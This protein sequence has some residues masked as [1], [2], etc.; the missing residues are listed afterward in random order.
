MSRIPDIAGLMAMVAGEPQSDRLVPHTG[1]S[2]RLT[3]IS[4]GIMAFLAVF[5]LSLSLASDRLAERW[6]SE[7][8]RSVTIRISAP[9]DQV[10]AQTDLVLKIL[11]TTPGIARARAL[12]DAEQKALLAPWFGPDVPVDTLPI[13]QLVEVI[14]DDQGFDAQGLRLRLQAE[15]PGAVLDDHSRWRAPLIRAAGRLTTLGW[16]AMVLIFAA[17][18]AMITLAAS[19]SLAANAQVIGVLRLVGATDAYI[20][21][22]FVRRFTLRA[23]TGA[24]VGMVAGLIAVWFLPAA[25][26]EASILT[27]LGLRGAEWLWPL[28]LPLVAALTGFAATYVTAQRTLRELD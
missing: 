15:T 24:A 6:G 14:E 19:A 2:A 11:K 10:K 22:A 13:P 16:L 27:G 20:A 21:R 1:I 4:A 28:I 3:A 25:Q 9:A 7:L 26:P 12:T 23:L 5:A 8:A 17:M 18:A